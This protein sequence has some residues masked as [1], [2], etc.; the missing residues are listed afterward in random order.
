MGRDGAARFALPAVLLGL[1]VSGLGRRPAL[2]R[3]IARWI[4]AHGMSGAGEMM[5]ES[6]AR[7][8]NRGR[9]VMVV[10]VALPRARASDRELAA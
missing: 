3:L 9:V 1:L 4:Y 5:P 7:R 6:A 8:G 10:G 2:R